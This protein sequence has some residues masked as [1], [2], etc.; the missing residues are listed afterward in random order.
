MKP[1]TPIPPHKDSS[2]LPTGKFTKS[3]TLACIRIAI[4]R[5]PLTDPYV[6]ISGIIINIVSWL[7]R[8]LS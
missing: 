6:F 4:N 1:P 5:Y 2:L 8:R 7:G 3:A